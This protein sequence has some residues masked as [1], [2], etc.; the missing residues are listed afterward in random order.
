M[1]ANRVRVVH[2]VQS[3]NYGGMERVIADLIAHTDP[4]R[5]ELH[6]LCLE[7]LGRFSS[8]LDRVAQL[9]V[10]SPMTRLS[11]L[12]PLALTRQIASIS[13]DI[14]HT[15][16]GVWFKGSL[17]ARRAGVASLIHTEHGRR[18]PDPHADR[19]FD[20]LAAR[21]TNVVVAVSERLARDLPRALHMPAHKLVCIPN[22]I[23]GDVYR[24]LPDTGKLRRELGLSPQ[25][26]I[27]GSIGRLEPI[28]AYDVMILAFARFAETDAGRDAHLVV[29]GEGSARRD[30]E[31]LSSRLGVSSRV[32]LLGWRD[33]VHDLLSAF[34]L[35]TMSSKS[36][37]TSISLLE[38]MSAGLVPVV[39]DVGGN[40]AV[41]GASLRSGLVPFG[42]VDALA[43]AWFA[44][45]QTHDDRHSRAKLARQRVTESFSIQAVAKA[46]DSLY[47]EAAARGRR[48]WP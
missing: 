6:L 30:L 28:K 39:T 38:A 23:D 20:G 27:I 17:A 31:Q 45:L 29:G 21:R 15:H 42:N 48:Q 46:Y 35:F 32:H 41:L 18:S 10:A 34:S 9:H 33:D 24:P 44:A 3:M 7:Y 11:I 22:G 12:N 14:V 36:E 37:G 13:P 40:G 43:E 47:V 16:S 1:T 4:E 19:L 8:G 2:V 5:F 25:A 26:T